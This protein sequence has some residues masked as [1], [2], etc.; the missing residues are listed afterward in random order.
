MVVGMHN[1]LTIEHD[2]NLVPVILSIGWQLSG[3]KDHDIKTW[4]LKVAN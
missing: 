3:R 4:N 1:S 2:F